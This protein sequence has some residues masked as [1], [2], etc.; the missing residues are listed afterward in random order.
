MS[1]QEALM[2]SL[3]QDPVLRSTFANVTFLDRPADLDRLRDRLLKAV[4][5]IPRLRQ[6][7]VD[8][9]GGLQA[10]A[11]VDDPL[12]DID[13][14]LRRVAVPPPGT[15]REVLDLA[16]VISADPFDRARPLWQFVLVEGLE[17]GRGAMIQKLHHTITDG[18]GGVRLST[19]F[20]DLQRD[21]DAPLDEGQ[22]APPEPPPARS[23][24]GNVADAVGRPLGLARRVAAELREGG[25][26]GFPGLR[27]IGLLL[28][29]RERA[30]VSMNVHDHHAAPLAE[31]VAAV[32]ARAPVAEAEIVG[33][34]PAEALSD[35]PPDVPLRGFDP[36]R[37]LIENAL[38]SLP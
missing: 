38:R 22:D 25:S 13:F 20:L 29:T 19:K 11:W 16:A 23:A 26:S 10:P 7:V 24:L 8:A 1:D 28:A 17:G 27:A 2:W 36:D 34:A 30:Q 35:F 14:H 4:E 3:E 37:H 18:E 32:R 33:L 9:P 5:D 12:F 31:I 21:A 15:E 6:R